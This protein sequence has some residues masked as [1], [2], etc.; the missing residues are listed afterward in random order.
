MKKH[1][2]DTFR[3]ISLMIAILV[4][5]VTLTELL[6]YYFNFA[7]HNLVLIYVLA[8]FLI[9][10]I[11]PGYYYGLFAAVVCTF[12][13]DFLI[14][15]PRLG[16]SF[17]VSSPF[18]L[19]T[20]LTVTLITSMLVS[21]LRSQQNHFEILYQIN[22]QLLSARSTDAIVSLINTSLTVHVEKPVIFYTGDPVRQPDSC[23][24]IEP[25]G[26]GYERYFVNE[27]EYKKVHNIFQG[28]KVP[29]DSHQL[30]A[31]G[32]IYYVPVSSNTHVTGVI[33]IYCG[34]RALKQNHLYYVHT[35]AGQVALAFELQHLSDQQKKLMIDTEKEK[36]R[37]TFL[38]SISHDFRTPV[39][40]IRGAC[41][42][43]QQHPDMPSQTRETLLAD[44]K[45]YADWLIRIVENI[46]TITRISDETLL[47]AK[48]TEAAEEIIAVAV[49][50]VRK[51]YPGREI[52]IQI[53]DSLLLV[54]MDATLIVQVLIN[55]IENSVKNSPP[56]Q[57]ILVELKE[58]N[59]TVIFRVADRGS[60]LAPELAPNPFDACLAEKTKPDASKG[61]GIGLSIC[62]TIIS[63]HNG[64]IWG[65]NRSRG[66][67]AFSFSLPME[68]KTNEI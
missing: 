7:Q 35:L 11:S 19:A 20:L 36:V 64:Q 4:A 53:P 66:G 18:T 25:K 26:K 51:R 5:T 68:N 14:V 55:L 59:Q 50:M 8:V 31:T 34:N 39:A 41:E 49:S 43:I 48:E 38:R 60:G 62:K 65:Y 47:I 12:A 67:A 45:D 10:C 24:D 22:R 40:T 57:P 61:T 16:F 23:F 37:S 3:Q 46:L 33:G 27:D 32:C 28:Q 56:E 15:T 9:S 44:I 54:P 58:H 29:P 63:A 52:Q 30:T 17:T 42:A 1:F 13:C 21:R 6:R 2:N